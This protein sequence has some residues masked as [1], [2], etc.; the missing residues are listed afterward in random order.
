MRSQN[1]NLAVKA[2][3]SDCDITELSCIEGLLK[4]LR[5]LIFN[6]IQAQGKIQLKSLEYFLYR[7][8]VNANVLKLK[9]LRGSISY[10]QEMVKGQSVKLL[11]LAKEDLQDL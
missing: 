8:E 6:A 7:V 2:L 9:T 3:A 1:F 4:M 11:Y 10:V 5:I